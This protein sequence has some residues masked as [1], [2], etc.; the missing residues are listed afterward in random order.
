MLSSVRD[1]LKLLVYSNQGGVSPLPI[2]SARRN[3]REIRYGTQ[4]AVFKTINHVH[5][6]ICGVRH[7]QAIE[8]GMNGGVVEASSVVRGKLNVTGEFERHDAPAFSTNWR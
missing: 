4:G 1:F 3:A 6:I 7:I 5:R 8:S 2:S